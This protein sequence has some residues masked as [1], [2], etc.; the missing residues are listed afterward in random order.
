MIFEPRLI[1]G[2]LVSIESVTAPQYNKRYKVVSLRHQG[3]ISDSVSGQAVT[4][5]GCFTGE[6]LKAVL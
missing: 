5:V 3:M 6:N 2:Q 4:T 1:V